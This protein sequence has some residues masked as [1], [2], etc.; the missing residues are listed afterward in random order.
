MN[1]C[2]NYDKEN[3]KTNY[4]I[5]DKKAIGVGYSACHPND[6]DVLSERTGGHIAELRAEI[7]YLQNYK[8]SNIKPGLNAL[9]HLYATMDHSNRFNPSSYEAT[10]LRKEIKNKEKEINKIN[11]KIEQLRKYLKEYIDDKDKM[12]NYY[13]TKNKIQDKNL[14]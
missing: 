14:I 13:R 1:I 4:I 3:G 2:Y 11:C 8:S 5:E 9:K 12:A 10:R 6:M 7:N